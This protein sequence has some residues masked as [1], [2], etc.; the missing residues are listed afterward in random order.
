MREG[1][2]D[3]YAPLVRRHQD[4]IFRLCFSM[5]GS[6]AEADDAAQDVFVKAYHA[7]AKFKGNSAFTTWLHRIAVNHCKDL[8]RG[9][10]RAKTESWDNLI[11][12]NHDQFEALFASEKDPHLST[13]NADL[14]H[15]ALG[16]LSEGNRIALILREVQG[17]TYQE[18]AEAMKTSV[19]GV[20]ARLLRAR[21]E[22][23][24]KLRHFIKAANV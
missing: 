8:L 7:L 21:T 16:L 19:D 20:K 4:R 14:V 15:R 1:D 24:E 9:R 22:L 10:T 13:E 23:E 2:K 11:E 12:K 5:L 6:A 17:L 3:A 18:I